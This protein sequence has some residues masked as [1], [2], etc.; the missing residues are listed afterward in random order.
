MNNRSICI[1]PLG[2]YGTRCY[3][4]RSSCLSNPCQND[5]FR[6]PI[7]ERLWKH[8]FICICPEEFSGK[9]CEVSKIRVSATL[10]RGIQV[11]SLLYAYLINV[12][13]K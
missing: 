11:P 6:I 5:G 1:C 8:M 10:S 2:T 9:Y 12:R 13:R 7:D 3:L 4:K